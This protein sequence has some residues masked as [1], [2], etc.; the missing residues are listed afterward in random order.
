MNPKTIKA[1]LFDSGDTLNRPKTGHW[2]IPPHFNEIVD[3]SKLSINSIVVRYAM[4]RGRA[5]LRKNHDIKTEEAE[6]RLFEGFYSI[7]LK[8]A[9][10]PNIDDCIIK[11][12]AKETVYNDEKFLFFEDVV[13]TL[14]VL[15]SRFQLGVVSVSWPSLE[16]V[17]INYGIRGYFKTFVISS[18]YDQYRSKKPLLEVALEQLGVE[19]FETIFIDDREKN[20][21]IARKMGIK[22]I[23]IDRYRNNRSKEMT[24]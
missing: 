9:G 12:L 10:Y 3:T 20:L 2:F 18:M 8:T 24:G 17:F 4:N 16:R 11:A 19:P 1:I 14:K 23:K 13:P 21:K 6:L 5:Y 7:F 15:S 22:P